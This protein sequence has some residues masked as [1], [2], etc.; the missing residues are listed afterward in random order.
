MISFIHSQ[1]QDNM[2]FIKSSNIYIDY[3]LG[4]KDFK[5]K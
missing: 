2:V 4:L 1:I 5:V 3:I